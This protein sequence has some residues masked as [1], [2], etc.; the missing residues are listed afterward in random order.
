[1]T[2]LPWWEHGE[3]HD[4]LALTFSPR[5]ATDNGPA[6]EH[7]CVPVK[8]HL[9]RQVLGHCVLTPDLDRGPASPTY[10]VALDKSV[11]LSEAVSS[12]TNTRC[13]CSDD[14]ALP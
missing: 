10:C 5:G 2:F 6:S 9:Q 13:P 12:C 8:L 1:M 14:S 3:Y 4:C 7:G 11:N